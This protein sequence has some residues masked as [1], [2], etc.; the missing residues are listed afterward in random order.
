MTSARIHE[1][2]TPFLARQLSDSQLGQI[3]TYIDLLL[4]WNARINLTAVRDPEQIVTRHFGESLF[5]AGHLFPNVESSEGQE[6]GT[7]V[8]DI[9]SGAGFPGL[10]LRIWAPTIF[11]TLVESNHKKATFLREVVRALTLTNVNV[12]AE[13]VE[14]LSGP[15]GRNDN[16]W[17][18]LLSAD[19]VTVRAVERF[20]NILPAAVSLT[21]TG[22]RLA[23]LIGLKQVPQLTE[24]APGVQ[25]SAPIPIPQ[26]RERVLSI[27]VRQ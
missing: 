4:R 25:W 17:Q 27:G 21:R 19:A 23:T 15:V 13:R 12:M 9:G 20:D 7:R 16:D 1:L 22:G 8:M 14:A 2:L 5:L 6:A 24:L 3:S 26:S 11:L 18:S 10:P